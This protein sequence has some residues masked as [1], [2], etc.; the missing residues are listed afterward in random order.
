MVEFSPV[1]DHMTKVSMARDVERS[2]SP[3]CENIIG[4]H[5]GTRVAM[6]ELRSTLPL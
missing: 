3:L 4:S 2:I 1:C 6:V 5:L